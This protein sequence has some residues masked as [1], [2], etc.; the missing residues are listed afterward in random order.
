MRRPLRSTLPLAVLAALALAAVHA[1]AA[2]GVRVWPLAHGRQAI[3]GAPAAPGFDA[4]T[5]ELALH[6]RERLAA[7]QATP[8]DPQRTALGALEH[9][10]GTAV[11]MRL[12]PETRTPRRLAAA[13]LEPAAGGLATRMLS[14]EERRRRTARAFLA[15][16]RTLL[17]LDDPDQ[18]LALV[19]DALDDLGRR[20]LR[21][22]Q[23][24]RGVPVW[25]AEVVVHLDARGNVDVMDGAFVPTPAEVSV[26]PTLDAAAAAVR[27]RAVLADGDGAD[28]GAADLVVYAPGDAPPRLAWRVELVRGIAWRWLVVV[29]AQRGDP[30]TTIDLLLDENVVG[31]GLDL[32]NDTRQLNV[33]HESQYFLVDTSK[34]MYDPTSNP[35]SPDTTREGIIVLDA[36]NCDR[37]TSPCAS[38]GHAHRAGARPDRDRPLDAPS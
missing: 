16:N 2:R 4:R 13:V 17:R 24:H 21:F 1:R 29:D 18:E 8:P 20:H 9:R 5:T 10:L 28:T 14:G 23:Q 35:P 11:T 37:L 25:P 31:S 22:A 12:R 30:L 3:A 15:A 33:W 34:Q 19:Q 32:F 7:L 36:H 6:L 26:T 27:A 38:G